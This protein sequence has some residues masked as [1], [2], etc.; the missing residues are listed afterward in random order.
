MTDPDGRHTIVFNGEIYNVGTLRR[1]LEGRGHAFRTT[2][3]TEVLLAGWREWREGVLERLRGMFAFAVHDAVSGEIFLARDRLG[4]KPLYVAR[5]TDGLAFASEVKALLALRGVE[6]VPDPTELAR[7]LTFLWVPDPGTLFRGIRQLEPGSWARWAGGRLDTRRYWRLPLDES[8]DGPEDGETVERVEALLEDAVR[9]RL[10]SDVSLGAF[11]SGGID[12]S[13]IVALMRRAGAGRVLTET[14]VFPREDRRYR[15]DEE[16][17]P[18]ARRVRDHFGDLEYREERLEVDVATLLPLLVW[19]ADDP[20]SDPAALSTYVICEAARSEATVMLAG[21]GAEELFAG[22]PRHRATL[23]G[24]RYARLPRVL[25]RSVVEPLVRRLPGAR[26]GPFLRPFRNLKKF[27]RSA[28]RPF[29]ERYL[30][31]VSYY[32]ADEL[33]TLLSGEVAREGEEDP[34]AR[35]RAHLDRSVGMDPVFR[36]THLDLHTFL[37]NLNLAYTDRASMAASVE[38][39]VPLVDHRLVEAVARLPSR[40]KLRRGRSK[41]VLREVAARHLPREIVE[42]AKTGFA[43]PVRS[44]TRGVLRP[45]IGEL[46]SPERVRRRGFL[47]PDA[48]GRVVADLQEGREDNALRVWA[49]LTLELWASTFLDGDG[50]SPVTL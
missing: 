20:V 11:L 3:D 49:L 28:G 9:E 5:T 36:M 42:R 6:A 34:W 45:V 30:G 41:W 37:P 33:D 35:H 32:D 29:E 22:Y 1:E 38:V 50:S 12:S 13:L 27:A 18:F 46:L 14:A 43:A 48:V 47:D 19:H 26:P 17:A 25:R 7:F 16:D 21:M 4:I 31:F 15:I 40:F 23:V 24:E 2:G 10:V 39:R 8:D 44:W